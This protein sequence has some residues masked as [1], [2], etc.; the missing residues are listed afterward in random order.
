MVKVLRSILAVFAGL[1]VGFLAVL[2]GEMIGHHLYPPPVGLDIHDARSL[3]EAMKIMPSGAFV[4]VILAWAVGSFAGA[5]VAAS[6]AAIGKTWHGLLI[7]ALFLGIGVLNMLMIPHPAWVWAAG[8]LMP[9]PIAYLGS[10]LA[11]RR[12]ATSAAST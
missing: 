7:G 10:L 12:V 9:L 1:F 3:S 8:L 11:S 4:A 2:G 5:W 6:I